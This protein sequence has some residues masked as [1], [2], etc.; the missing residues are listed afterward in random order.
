MEA[1]SLPVAV[2]VSTM[3]GRVAPE[4]KAGGHPHGMGMMF[5]SGPDFSKSYVETVKL[6]FDSIVVS[7]GRN[8]CSTE[9]YKSLAPEVYVIGDAVTPGDV[10]NCTSTAYAAAMAL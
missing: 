7:G 6:E 3:G 8:S 1:A 5:G 10:K 4:V 2:N 9:L